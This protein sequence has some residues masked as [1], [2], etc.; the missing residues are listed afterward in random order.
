MGRPPYQDKWRDGE[1]V[2]KGRRECADRFA[3]IAEELGEVRHVVDVGGWDGYFAR[4]FVEAGRA[5]K[6]GRAYQA[7]V[8]VDEGA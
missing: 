1:L 4:R 5:F 7:A 6:I 8:V 2:E 3:A